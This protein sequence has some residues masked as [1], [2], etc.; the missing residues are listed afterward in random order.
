[1][2]PICLESPSISVSHLDVKGAL[3]VVA[4]VGVMKIFENLMTEFAQGME[5]PNFLGKFV[6][7]VKLKLFLAIKE[8]FAFGNAQA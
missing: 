4:N 1:V 5:F 7:V 6:N 2:A 3:R 8:E